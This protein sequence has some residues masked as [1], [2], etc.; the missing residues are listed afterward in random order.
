MSYPQG[1]LYQPSASLALYSCPAYSTSVISGPRTD[2][3][4][5]SSSGSAFSPYA[6]STAFTAPSPGYNSHLQYGADPAAAAAA[7]FSSYVGSPYDHTPGMAGSLGYHPYA[8]PLGSYPYGDPAYRKNATRDATATLK[9]WLNE[10]RKNPYPTKGEKIMLAIITKM[11]L[12]QVSTWFANARRRLKKEN[13]MTWT[14]RN[15]SEDEEEEENIDLEKNDEDEPQKP[16]DKGDPE[17]T[18]AGGAEQ[19]ASSGCERLQGPPTPA[20]KETEGSLSDSD[21]KAPSSEGRL[22]ALPGPP[23]PG[24]SSP[25]GP[26]AARLAEDP[27]PHYP[28]GAPAPAPGPHPAAGELPPG[29]GG[30]SVI[31]SPPPPPPQAVLAKPKLW[32]LA[33]IATSSDKVKDGGGGSEGSPC[34]PCPGPVAGQALGGS[35]G[36]PVPAPSRSPSAQCPFPGGTVLSRPLYY[37]APFYPGYTNYGS[38][39]HLH[40]HPGHGPGPTTGPGSHF[41]GLNQ[42]VLNRADALAKDPK[43]LRSQSQLDLCKDSPY[44]LKKGMSDI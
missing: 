9:A 40:G 17:G 30:P 5:R 25:A 8:A 18:E 31:H 7:A 2:E 23:R 4:G 33:E 35:R 38:F 1:Y 3:L 11:T 10:H 24:R 12:T 14:P 39:G 32:S 15:R 37:T 28:S 21:F 22:D 34:P 26:A 36:S 29:P 20:G 19:K 16:E 43:M 27:A 42:T 41:N 13:K 44:E 6:G